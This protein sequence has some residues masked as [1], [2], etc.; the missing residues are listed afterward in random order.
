MSIPWTTW[1]ND[2]VIFGAHHIPRTRRS[3]AFSCTRWRKCMTSVAISIPASFPSRAIWIR[4]RRISNASSRNCSPRNRRNAGTT[5]VL[6]AM[7][8]WYGRSS[9]PIGVVRVYAPATRRDWR[10]FAAELDRKTLGME[11]RVADRFLAL[12]SDRQQAKLRK[13]ITAIEESV[14]DGMA[15]AQS[16]HSRRGQHAAW[17][18]TPL[19]T[20]DED[21]MKR[22]PAYQ[23]LSRRAVREE[24]HFTEA[25]GE[26]VRENRP[27]RVPPTASS[28]LQGYRFP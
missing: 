3:S 9:K 13:E 16:M 5:L 6:N 11:H 15:G 24:L 23:Q 12:L 17:C 7:V 8:P 25:Q 10:N 19:G 28:F 1:L 4:S 2:D 22:F 21:P 27:D 18:L 20:S 26:T 14:D